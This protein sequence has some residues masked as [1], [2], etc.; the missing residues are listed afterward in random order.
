MLAVDFSIFCL[1]EREMGE[2][3]LCGYIP[4]TCGVAFWLQTL[5]SLYS[6]DCVI[7]VMVGIT[8]VKS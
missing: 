4:D 3:R 7:M 5:S 1:S 6:V 2:G 8:Y